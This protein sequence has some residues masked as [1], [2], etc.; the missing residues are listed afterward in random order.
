[1]RSFG[2]HFKNYSNIRLRIQICTIICWLLF[3]VTELFIPQL[4]SDG[5]HH[6]QLDIICRPT[7][8]FIIKV[9]NKPIKIKG[10]IK[11]AN[12]Y[13]NLI[14]NIIFRTITLFL[15]FV[16][17]KS[18]SLWLCL[19]LGVSGLHFENQH[20]VTSLQRSFSDT[21]IPLIEFGHPSR[22]FLDTCLPLKNSWG[23]FV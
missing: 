19:T 5:T 2:T 18:H 7:C 23:N 4:S 12:N 13:N 1:M 3:R 8:S 6:V 15:P 10:P 16:Q 22:A 14:M 17:N 9:C 11:Q 21:F 20:S